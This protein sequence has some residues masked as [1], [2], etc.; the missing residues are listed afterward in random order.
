M[1]SI[2]YQQ[3]LN[4]KQ[5]YLTKLL[6]NSQPPVLEVF[7]SLEQ[8]YRMR[9]EFRIWHDGD[10]C[11]YAMFSET[12]KA[13]KREVHKLISF[14]VAHHNISNLMPKLLDQIQ[15]NSILQSRLFQAEFLTT[16]AGDTLVTLIYHKK[17]DDEWYKAAVLLAA[18]LNV[19]IIGRSRG[20][21]VV[22]DRD[23]VVEKLSVHGDIF[24]YQ[25]KEGG[26]TQ[27]N[28]IIC[29][30][31]LEWACDVAK[32]IEHGDLLELYCGNGNF[33]LPLSRYFRQ[34]LA[35]EVS[36][37]SVQAA[38]WNINTMEANNIALVRLSAEEFTQAFKG[39]RIFKRLID[40]KI[41]LNNYQFSTVFVD[42]P[43]AGIDQQT[44]KLLQN[45]DNIIY[46]SCNP[47]TLHENLHTLNQ[48]HTI[49]RV[50]LFDQFPFTH[51]IESSVWL[52]RR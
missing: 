2:A 5:Q 28:A 50:A 10:R 16:L 11:S 39:V 21:K 41:D 17:L 48:T 43:R 42:P 35:T 29:Q 36:K 51:H 40:E 47:I 1:T 4:N 9:A 12:D 49:K 45:F 14:D 25:Q 34:V 24:H 20:Q 8:H 3:Q 31:M 52:Q 19:Q 7:P 32:I 30:H 44:L 37:T 26:F 13:G 23:Y 6:A 15:L 22:L 27:P 18:N 46:V 38:R 33:T